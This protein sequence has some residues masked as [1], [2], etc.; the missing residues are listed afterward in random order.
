[1]AFASKNMKILNYNVIFRNTKDRFEFKFDND[2][3]YDIEKWRCK[4]ER[5]INEW[6][7]HLESKNWWSKKLEEDFI[8]AYK[9]EYGERK[10]D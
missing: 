4:T 9:K 5:D 7:A 3:V 1:M 10:I 8:Q 2:F 6:I